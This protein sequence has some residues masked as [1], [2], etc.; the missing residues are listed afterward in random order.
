MAAVPA[1]TPHLIP[2]PST[3]DNPDGN[4]QD[5][6]GIREDAPAG[7]QVWVPRIQFG[8]DGEGRNDGQ[9]AGHHSGCDRVE[10]VR[11]FLN[12]AA[13]A[14]GAG[15]FSH[16]ISSLC[17]GLIAFVA[18]I[19]RPGCSNGRQKSAR[20]DQTLRA[21]YGEIVLIGERFGKR[22]RHGAPSSIL[23]GRPL[24]KR[25]GAE[26]SQWSCGHISLWYYIQSTPGH[27]SCKRTKKTRLTGRVPP[28]G[29]FSTFGNYAIRPGWKSSSM[30]L[31][32]FSML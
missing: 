1:D 7:Q 21:F 13:F 22:C 11:L 28:L 4:G 8:G 27:A 25:P 9:N 32:N 30:I 19:I 23:T 31:Y 26:N 29:I 24:K 17:S 2:V 15:L 3:A 20:H 5:S 6:Q 14:V 18:L 16:K 12:L 10:S